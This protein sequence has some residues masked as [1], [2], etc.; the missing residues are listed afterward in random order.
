MKTIITVLVLITFTFIPLKAFENVDVCHF[1]GF[2][3]YNAQFEDG[4]IVYVLEEETGYIMQWVV[5]NPDGSFGITVNTDEF[6]FVAESV[7]DNRRFVMSN[8]DLNA[9][10]NNEVII[11]T[12]YFYFIPTVY[13]RE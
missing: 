12:R 8:D 1:E 13:G 6:I 5:A 3:Y 2:V 11:N 10:G 4:A 9:C 7:L